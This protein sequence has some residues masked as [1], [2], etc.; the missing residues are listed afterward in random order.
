MSRDIR[1]FM[2]VKTKQLMSD[3]SVVCWCIVHNQND[4]NNYIRC[5]KEVYQSVYRGEVHFSPEDDYIASGQNIGESCFPLSW[6]LENT[7]VPSFCS[8]LIIAVFIS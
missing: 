4:P 5:C 7:L 8:Q 1:K 2:H 6:S 3:T